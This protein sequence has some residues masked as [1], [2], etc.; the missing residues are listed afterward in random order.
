MKIKAARL[1]ILTL[2]LCVVAANALFSMRLTMDD[3]I[4]LLLARNVLQSPWF[5]Q[6][7]P[8]YFEGLYVPDLAST[9]HAL[10]LT[11]Y[12][13]ALIAQLANGFTE[14]SQ[15]LGFLVFPLILSYSMYLLARRFT[16]H[17]LLAS[18]NLM[19]LPVVFVMSHTLMTDIPQM[20]LSVASVGLFCSG[21]E[22]RRWR[23]TSAAAMSATLA[24]FIS[25]ASLLPDPFARVFGAR[26]CAGPSRARH[27]RDHSG[28]AQS[29]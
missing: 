27:N 17:P 4:Y 16:A 29:G 1:P 6:D 2:F 12:W 24:A 11:S 13:M 20:A 22:H 18:L 26:C 10:P 7:R 9:E 3:S 25:Y 8:T 14:I 23:R 15:H 21:V 19:F 5:P 28:C